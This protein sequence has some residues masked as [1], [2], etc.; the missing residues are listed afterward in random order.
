[1][2][3][4]QKK[5]IHHAEKQHGEK[6][7]KEQDKQAENG[8][9]FFFSRYANA[10]HGAKKTKDVVR[11]AKESAKKQGKRAKHAFG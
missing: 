6:I 4:V 11:Y 7:K 3:S 5:A 8:G 9:A 2:A 1:M 10:E